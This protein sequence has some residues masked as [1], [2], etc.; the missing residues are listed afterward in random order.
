MELY[1]NISF[2]YTSKGTINIVS[3]LVLIIST[4]GYINLICILLIRQIRH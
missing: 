2:Y 1:S 4:S 3:V